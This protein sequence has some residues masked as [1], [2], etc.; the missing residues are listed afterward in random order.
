M[1]A[2]V[3]TAALL[4]VFSAGAFAKIDDNRL[5]GDPNSPSSTSSFVAVVEATPAPPAFHARHKHKGGRK[6]P[7]CTSSDAAGPT[8]VPGAAKPSGGFQPAG[9]ARPTGGFGRRPGGHPK[10]KP[11][12]Y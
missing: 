10:N 4:A 9:V 8:Q 12:P 1:K 7:S 5:P 6:R 3:I 11:H 2:T